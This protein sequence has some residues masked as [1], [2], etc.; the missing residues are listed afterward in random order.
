MSS[1]PARFELSVTN[2]ANVW[3]LPLIPKGDKARTVT[4]GIAATWYTNLYSILLVH[5]R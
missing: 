4:L 5:S 2:E 1:F 3:K